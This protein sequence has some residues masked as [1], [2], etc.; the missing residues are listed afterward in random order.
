ME[1]KK[2]KKDVIV[3]ED[4]TWKMVI[5]NLQALLNHV[6]IDLLAKINLCI[7]PSHPNNMKPSSCSTRCSKKA[8]QL[9]QMP[10]KKEVSQKNLVKS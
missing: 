1:N 9:L 10:L 3:M 4:T 2:N 5:P 8:T 6:N 7:I